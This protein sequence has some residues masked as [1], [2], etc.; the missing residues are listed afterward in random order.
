MTF[1]YRVQVQ[2]IDG[3]IRTWHEDG[4]SA[5]VIRAAGCQSPVQLQS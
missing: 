1:I 3:D 2:L 5:E 4:N